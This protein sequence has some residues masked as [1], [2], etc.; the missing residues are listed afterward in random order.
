MYSM[1]KK[2][3]PRLKYIIIRVTDMERQTLR[4]EA[5]EYSKSLSTYIRHK[6]GLHEKSK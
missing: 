3:D 5:M 2:K 1:N 6:L 4:E